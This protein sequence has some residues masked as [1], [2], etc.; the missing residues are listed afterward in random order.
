MK[1]NK[2]AFAISKKH[3]SQKILSLLIATVLLSNAGS[4]HAAINQ[5]TGV[6][7]TDWDDL[8]NWS[9]AE[10]PTK[11]SGIQ[12]DNG[13]VM[14]GANGASSNSS[15]G[16]SSGSAAMVTVDGTT[17]TVGIPSTGM[18]GSQLI[19]DQGNGKLL[20]ENGG[21]V[22]Y[23]ANAKTILGNSAGSKGEVVVSG[24][25]SVWSSIYMDVSHPSNQTVVTVG[26]F[27]SGKLSVLNGASV[28]TPR[29]FSI[30]HGVGSQGII[31]VSGA[32]STLLSG[33][34]TLG[35][36]G[37]AGLSMLD[38]EGHFIVEDGGEATIYGGLYFGR[39]KNGASQTVTVNGQ[40]S[41]VT[42]FG[43]LEIG[44]GGKTG[45]LNVSGGAQLYTMHTAGSTYVAEGQGVIGDGRGSVGGTA[46]ANIT[47]SGSYWYMQQDAI[48]GYLANGYLNISD[49]AKVE[50]SRGRIGLMTGY[51]GTVTVTG[52][53]SSWDNYDSVV[54]GSNGNG[55]VTVSDKGL[56]NVTNAITI[57]ENAGSTGALNFGSA[58][59]QTAK[60]TGT[61]NASQIIFG[62]G[63]GRVVFNHNETNYQFGHLLSGTGT[64]VA[65][66]GTTIFSGNQTYSGQ[67]EIHS[68][69]IL[70]AGI[71]NAFSANS[72]YKVSSGGIMDLAGYSQTLGNVTNAGCIRF[73]TEAIGSGQSHNQL[74]IDGNLHLDGGEFIYDTVLN[75]DSSATDYLLVTGNTSGTG[76]IRVLNA[77]GIGSETLD[78]IKIVEILGQSDGEFVKAP[79]HRIV[80]GIYE[81][82]VARGTPTTRAGGDNNH[83]YLT[84]VGSNG[85]KI[86][87]PEVSAYSANLAMS[88]T[89]FTHSMHDRLG[90]PQ[91]VESLQGQV[92]NPTSLWLRIIGGHTRS[93]DT[94]NYQLKTQTNRVVVQGGGEIA[95]WSNGGLDRGHLGL[96]FGYGKANS[97]SDSIRTLHRARGSV[98]GYS[99]GV[100]GTWYSND[101]EKT[102]L[103]VD[104]WAQYN[105]FKNEVKGDY[106]GSEKYDSDGV[107]MSLETGYTFKVMDQARNKKG[108]IQPQAQIV[109]MNVKADD[110]KEGNGT[111]VSG[112]GNGNVMTRL[113]VRAYLQGY[114]MMDDGKDRI[115]QPFVE[116]NWI[117]NTKA[118]GTELNGQKVEQKGT[119]NQVELKLG[120]EGQ[121]NKQLTVWGNVSERLGGNGYGDTSGV[122]G[123][124][125]AF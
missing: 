30:A 112:S 58:E 12:I 103:Y 5:W 49:G 47:G 113:G 13:N 56:V 26:E 116:T 1:N 88:N 66:G 43:D 110:H 52:Q 61:V 95:G 76:Y 70:K 8:N 14:M 101:A 36:T 115:F 40:D 100:Y 87:R 33:N 91:Y 82:D 94:T 9:L 120:L 41:K 71:N 121:L 46:I 104:S 106:I 32:G 99:A 98:D 62:A 111:R 54:I 55:S 7:S 123:V 10:L 34:G 24:A 28:I 117:H 78:G 118:F 125:Y 21:K 89:L 105:W 3:P 65:D 17:W 102:G 45:I 11:N 68:G 15:I 84:S 114:H 64:V 74:I 63:D 96:M 67:T 69:A 48:V 92:Q 83:W 19:G 35:D 4:L 42:H 29:G 37:W 2:Y 107:V 79:N 25:G 57:A 51:G 124:K 119:R 85:E 122:I 109:W 93:R 53:G 86:V 22:Y 18:V 38:G 6:V 50:N 27:G 23:A 108:F 72:N 39:G 73:R 80:A 59:G 81:Y 77:G 31:L 20:I 44:W 16:G 60:S 97:N 90:E 75:D